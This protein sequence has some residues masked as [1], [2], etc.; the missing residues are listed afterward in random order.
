MS[1]DSNGGKMQTPYRTRGKADTVVMGYFHVLPP[2]ILRGHIPMKGNEFTL[3][4]QNHL[5]HGFHEDLA[6][7]AHDLQQRGDSFTPTGDNSHEPLETLS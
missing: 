1:Y 7:V 2:S 4:D 6:A 3:R 5:S